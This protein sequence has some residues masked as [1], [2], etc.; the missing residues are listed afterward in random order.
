MKNEKYYYIWLYS[1]KNDIRNSKLLYRV[2]GRKFFSVLNGYMWN[3]TRYKANYFRD[4]LEEG[5]IIELTRT[6]NGRP[7]L[8]IFD[9]VCICLETEIDSNLFETVINID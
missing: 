7:F 9:K 1:S 2:S 5:E 3:I 8:N 6:I 4:N